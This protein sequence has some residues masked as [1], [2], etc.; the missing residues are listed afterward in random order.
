MRAWQI[1][2]AAALVGAPCVGA[3]APVPQDTTAKP[4]QLTRPRTDTKRKRLHMRSDTGALRSAPNAGP[5][6]GLSSGAVTPSVGM[7]GNNANANNSNGRT[8]TP[9]QGSPPTPVP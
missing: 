2:L 3:Q 1:A 6:I 5:G 7:T 9:S 4:H 8:A